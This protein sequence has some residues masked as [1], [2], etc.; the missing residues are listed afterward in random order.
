MRRPRRRCPQAGCHVIAAGSR[1]ERGA[2]VDVVRADGYV[3]EERRAGVAVEE[4]VG[5]TTEAIA[6][7][8]ER[9]AV[10]VRGH[11]GK[12]WR[13]RARTAKTSTIR[14]CR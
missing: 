7:V 3:A 5:P 14:R 1:V 4:L 12:E 11:R 2:A 6:A 13:R 10:G 9:V 8:G